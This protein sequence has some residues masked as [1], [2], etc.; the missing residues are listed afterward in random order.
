MKGKLLLFTLVASTVVLVVATAW[1][2]TDFVAETIYAYKGGPIPPD[3]LGYFI[4]WPVLAWGMVTHASYLQ[5]ELEL[6]FCW[7]VVAWV[8]LAGAGVQAYQRVYV[9]LGPPVL[10]AFGQGHAVLV[11][12]SVLAI[13]AIVHVARASWWAVLLMAAA[14]ALRADMVVFAPVV[15][16]YAPNRRAAAQ[17]LA[18]LAGVVVLL[19]VAVVY[20]PLSLGA[21]TGSVFHVG[22]VTSPASLWSFAWGGV[23][24]VNWAHLVIPLQLGLVAV[25]FR[26]AGFRALSAAVVVGAFRATLDPWFVVYYLTPAWMALVMWVRERAELTKRCAVCRLAMREHGYVDRTHHI[27]VRGSL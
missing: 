17:R 5:I 27:Y 19:L 15:V 14:I 4:E 20:E 7:L 6:A 24:A 26:V 13:A 12:A 18:L 16:L 11:V 23:L 3:P 22:R 25:V 21:L 8:L 9:L 10:M 1:E 2:Q